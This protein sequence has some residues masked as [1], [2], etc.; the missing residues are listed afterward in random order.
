[1]DCNKKYTTLIQRCSS[2]LECSVHGWG[3][4]WC[5]IRA[6][7]IWCPIRA[8]WRFTR[9]RFISFCHFSFYIA[10]VIPVIGQLSLFH[11]KECIWAGAAEPEASHKPN[12][13]TPR[14]YGGGKGIVEF[15]FSGL[16]LAVGTTMKLSWRTPWLGRAC[17]LSSIAA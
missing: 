11:G 15:L 12:I 14:L 17:D 13:P 6:P 9:R 3:W 7:S 4:V 8:P 16:A 5:F 2:K 1:M 10:T